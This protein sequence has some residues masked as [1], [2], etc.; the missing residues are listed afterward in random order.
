MHL[1]INNYY[2]SA[3][4]GIAPIFSLVYVNARTVPLAVTEFRFFV[5]NNEM[6]MTSGHPPATDEIDLVELAQALWGQRLLIALCTVFFT[7]LALG[8]SYTVTPTYTSQ[9]T[10]APASINSFGMLAG[11]LNLRRP[12]QG[13]SAIS[14]GIRL[15]NDAFDVLVDNLNSQ[16][17]RRGF[18]EANAAYRQ[19]T[20]QASRGRQMADPVSLNATGTE[21]ELSKAFIDA[22]LAYATATTAVQLNEFL[23]GMGVAGEVEVSALYRLEQSATVP[24]VPVKPKRMLIIALGF[25]LGGMVGVFIGLIRSMLTKRISRNV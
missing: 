1:C 7:L 17:V 22:Y 4:R 13:E 19:V 14:G 5:I 15:A 18:D 21:P 11:T 12:T 16:I 3:C 25:V 6:E 2:H 10:I 20:F 24:S 9:A 8:Y 23:N